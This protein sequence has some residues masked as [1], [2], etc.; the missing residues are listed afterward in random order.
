MP[1]LRPENLK[2]LADRTS[3]EQ[4][5]IATL[6]GIRS[7]EVRREKARMSAMWANWL[8]EE[9]GITIDGK[10]Q[11]LS[12]KALLERITTKILIEG[13]PTSVAMMRLML[14]ATEGAK[15]RLSGP[16]GDDL[17]KAF[18]SKPEAELRAI[19]GIPELE[20]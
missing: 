13:S 8:S 9:H 1:T 17:F 19:A 15:S 3:E 12:G 7:G 16:D 2:S 4:R 14:D 11:K 5:K 20:L 18:D 6:G 10:M